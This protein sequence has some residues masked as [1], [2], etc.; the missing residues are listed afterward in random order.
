M[1]TKSNAGSG[2]SLLHC[3]AGGCNVLPLRSLKPRP[4]LKLLK[5]AAPAVNSRTARCSP[6]QAVKTP[7]NGAVG[8]NSSSNGNDAF[9]KVSVDE[10]DDFDPSTSN[11]PVTPLLDTV[12]YPV[13]IKNFNK[14]QLKQLCKEL[15]EDIIY[16]V[17]STGGHLGAS[18]GVT[19][20]TVALHYVF[21]AP[22]DKI[23]WDVGHQ[24]YP[25][26]ILTGRRSRMP[27]IRQTGGMSGM[28]TTLHTMPPRL[29]CS[30]ALLSLLRPYPQTR[31][32]TTWL[33]L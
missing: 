5:A 32:C 22:E 17:S 19:D 13:H 11:K 14:R 33:S 1:C 20:L 12:N 15:R 9:D 16:N 10:L 21:N 24:A 28:S 2:L 7:V 31:V 27:T 29:P 4:A 25:H 18:L 26:K 30:T 23:I 6:V 8:N 3:L